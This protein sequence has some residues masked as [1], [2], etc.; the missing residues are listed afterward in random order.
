MARMPPPSRRHPPPLRLT[1]RSWTPV[2]ILVALVNC[3]AAALFCSLS[4]ATPLD[5]PI[6]PAHDA[7][8]PALSDGSPA[9]VTSAAPSRAAAAAERGGP[10]RA[11]RSRSPLMAKKL[12]SP[13]LE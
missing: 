3:A 6:T 8:A 13:K 5:L 1:V 11:G 10:P 9:S 4:T 2:F 7:E 12:L